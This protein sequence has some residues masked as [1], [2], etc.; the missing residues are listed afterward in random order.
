MTTTSMSASAAVQLRAAWDACDESRELP[1]ELRRMFERRLGA[2]LSALRVHTGPAADAAARRFQADAVAC[3]S[4]VFFRDGAYRPDE[5]CGLWLL[6]HEV[7]HVAQQASGRGPRGAAG[8]GAVPAV[9]RAG[10]AWEAEA[11]RFADA[12]LTG[13]AVAGGPRPRAAV[14]V[15]P[16]LSGSVQCHDSFEH[17]ILGDVGTVDLMAVASG[18]G[19][20]RKAVLERQ[21]QL[22]ALWKDHPKA[23]TAKT[24]TDRF[25]EIQV[26][27]IGPDG[28]LATYGDLNALP[29]YLANPA[30]IDQMPGDILLPILQVIRQESYNKYTLILTGT[31]PNVTFADAACAP[32]RSGMINRIV[33]TAALDTLTMGLGPAGQDHYQGLLARNACHFAPFSW[34]RWQ[35]SHRAAREVAERAHRASGNEK[36][37]LTAEAWRLHGYA[38]HFL[39]DSFAAGHLTNKTLVMQWF[40]EWA[41][42]QAL[43]PFADWDDVRYMTAALQPG[44]AGLDLYDPLNPGP[45]IDPQTVQ[46]SADLYTRMLAGG[47]GPGREDGR[48]VGYRD[49]LTFLTSA[50]AQFGAASLHDYYND[51]SVTATSIHTPK[52]FVLWG[53]NTLLTGADGVPGVQETSGAAQESQKALREIL[54]QGGTGISVRDIQDR[55][56]TKIA[57]HTGRLLELK[58]WATT[59]KGWCEENVFAPIE[60]RIT[61]LLLRIAS[62]RLGT[63]SRDQSLAESW[64]SGLGGKGTWNEVT[65]LADGTRA[66]AAADGYVYELDPRTGVPK[67]KIELAG[68]GG[69]V[70]TKLVAD[71]T[72][73]YLGVKGRVHALPLTRSWGAK[74]EWTSEVL[75][76]RTENHPVDVLLQGG[77]LYAGTNSFVHELNIATGQST[78]KIELGEGLGDYATRL[79][80]RGT[81]IYV[82]THGYVYALRTDLAWGSKPMWS[83]A[84]PT[85]ASWPVQVR[86]FGDRLFAAS[87]GYLSEVHTTGGVLEQYILLADAAGSGDYTADMVSDGAFLYC[88]MHSWVYALSLDPKQKWG[89]EPAWTS[90]KVGGTAWHQVGLVYQNDQLYAACNGYVYELDVLNGREKHSSLIT[91]RLGAGDYLTT[92]TSDGSTLYLGTHGYAYRVQTTDLEP[93]PT[94]AWPLS[95]TSG[96][97][98]PDLRGKYQA[99]AAGGVTWQPLAAL[100]ACARFSA[101]GMSIQTSGPV[102]DTGVGRS[103][104]VTAWVRPDQ[105]PQQ[106]GATS[107]IVTQDGNAVSAFSL[108]YRQDSKSWAFSRP[109]ADIMNPVVKS[110]TAKTPVAVGAWTHLT[111]VYDADAGELRIH[112]DGGPAAVEKVDRNSAF[113]TGRSLVIGRGKFNNNPVGWLNGAVRDVRV[114][115]H[116]LDPALVTPPATSFWRLADSAKDERGDHAGS[117]VHVDWRKETGIGGYAAFNGGSSA[118][119]TAQPVLYTGPGG[120]FTVGAWVRMTALPPGAVTI[121]CQET[122]MFTSAFALRYSTTGSAGWCFTRYTVDRPTAPSVTAASRI[123]AAPGV[124]THV[125]GV[126]NASTMR[127]EIYV[128]GDRKDAQTLDPAQILTATAGMTIGRGKL[129]GQPTEWLNGGVRDVR[130]YGQALS[131]EQIRG[132]LYA[133]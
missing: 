123:A 128:N 27:Q 112:V 48:L 95:Q 20:H 101:S 58:E 114:Y 36:I 24:V 47:I 127:L 26:F 13:R 43:L 34:H 91:D 42:N 108:E 57:D 68:V 19:A 53:D 46:E 119:T 63:V 55:F 90:E 94:A 92:L 15:R 61:E 93:T 99:A 86:V 82:G 124:W 74:P 32:W 29:D 54:A 51:H 23:V 14:V 44:L 67:Q 133:G 73:L 117:A 120:S 98:V 35:I 16:G 37:R 18:V 25:P 96:T 21:I 85:V 60:K 59:Q 6:A 88:G 105:L 106:T 132:L 111:G 69:D 62:P 52:P 116:A 5:P 8:R 56:P 22:M 103:F 33:E 17:R 126:F 131:A 89:K 50:V 113:A 110:A 70:F 1:G 109:V 102:L 9:G 2:D 104:T 66:F 122:T 7:A 78:R 79:T 41:E 38:D 12:V 39:Q 115:Q 121:A 84:M 64:Y 31:D 4:A 97:I 80:A 40:T 125:T 3:G 28:V 72:R 100:G 11:D 76:G 130:A 129:E 83:C 107:A 45:S 81:W 65:L 10:D 77:R 118:V 30:E 75:S 87:G 49:Y 71:G